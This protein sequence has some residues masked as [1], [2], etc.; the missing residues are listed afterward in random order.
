MVFSDLHQRFGSGPV[1][2]PLRP[3][4]PARARPRRGARPPLRIREND[5]KT[6]QTSRVR[7]G[8]PESS[9]RDNKRRSQPSPLHFSSASRVFRDSRITCSMFLFVLAMAP[10]PARHSRSF[11]L[12][13]ETV[14]RAT[15][16]R[17]VW[18][19]NALK[20][21]QL[22]CAAR[23]FEVAEATPKNLNGAL[24]LPPDETSRRSVATA[25]SNPFTAGW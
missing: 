11:G 24:T 19:K 18:R 17:L 2:P 21:T 10:S 25:A 12:S 6:E 22:T 14:I 15:G 7:S 9:V 4:G 20:C 16:S 13:S 5:E 1:P 8:R 3:G 23:S